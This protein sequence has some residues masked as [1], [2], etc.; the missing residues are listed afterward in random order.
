MRR[1]RLLTDAMIHGTGNLSGLAEMEKVTILG[2]V[3]NSAREGLVSLADRW[4]SLG[5]CGQAAE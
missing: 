5:R 1:K 4:R 2:G 3:D